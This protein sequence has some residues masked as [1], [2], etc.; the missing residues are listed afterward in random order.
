MTVFT[1]S[2]RANYALVLI[3]KVL[4]LQQAPHR[5]GRP[6]LGRGCSRYR[7]LQPG[8]RRAMGAVPSPTSRTTARQVVPVTSTHPA[9]PQVRPPF[10]HEP[11]APSHSQ[12]R[13]KALVL[14]ILRRMRIVCVFGCFK[15]TYFLPWTLNSCQNILKQ[16]LSAI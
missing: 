2:T 16:I 15:L 11:L 14:F 12:A 4:I 6:T 1:F 3:A 9:R 8:S 5:T 7:Q 10:L 13:L